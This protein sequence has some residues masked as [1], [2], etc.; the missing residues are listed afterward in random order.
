MISWSLIKL[1]IIFKFELQ[2][3]LNY[4]FLFCSLVC[5]ISISFLAFVTFREIRRTLLKQFPSKIR[6]FSHTRLSFLSQ[7]FHLIELINSKMWLAWKLYEKITKS[8]PFYSLNMQHVCTAIF[9]HAI[10]FN[11][12]N[13]VVWIFLHYPASSLWL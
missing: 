9:I 13:H 12:L 5:L 4:I 7:Y 6:K 8:N 2:Q 10:N 1:K 3:S 11:F